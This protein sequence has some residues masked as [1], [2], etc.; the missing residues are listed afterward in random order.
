MAAR[1]SVGSRICLFWTRVLLRFVQFASSLVAYI[2]L[3]TAGITYQSTAGGRV[4]AVVV[5]SGAMNFARVI[6]LLAFL[7]AFAFLVF[8]EWL[9]LCVHPVIYCEKIMDFVLLVCLVVA[10]LVLLLSNMTLHCR[11]GYDRFV[12]CGEV[13]LAV[14]M[15]FLSALAFL[16]TVL[17]GQS[18]ED[19]E[20]RQ[21]RDREATERAGLDERES[22]AYS[23]HGEATPVPV[24]TAQ[25]A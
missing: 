16:L 20:R 13:Y 9:R 19:H 8:V 10:N 1:K 21:S 23:Q 4:I 5:T 15:T 3:Q 14:A 2:A 25:P 18:D 17:I 7:Y 6:N 24:V 22:G 12:H 11:R